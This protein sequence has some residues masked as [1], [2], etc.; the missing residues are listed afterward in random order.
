MDRS[1]FAYQARKCT[2]CSLDTSYRNQSLYFP[3]A[4]I[5]AAGKSTTLEKQIKFLFFLGCYDKLLYIIVSIDL[6]LPRKS[7]SCTVFCS[8]I[9]LNLA[10]I[11]MYCKPLTNIVNQQS[12]S[13]LAYFMMLTSKQEFVKGKKVWLYREECGKRIWI[14]NIM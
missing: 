12:H 9:H 10:K 14:Y 5:A 1:V 7:L 13:C 4:K 6:V 8:E 2:T 11:R 3:S